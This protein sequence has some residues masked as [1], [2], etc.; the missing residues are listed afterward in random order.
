[1]G[2]VA[3]EHSDLFVTSIIYGRLIQEQSTFIS[4]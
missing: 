1:M 3:F 2:I 4:A